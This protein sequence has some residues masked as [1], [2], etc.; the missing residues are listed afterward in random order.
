MKR[1]L[2]KLPDDFS[3]HISTKNTFRS[4][5]DRKK[6]PSS[7]STCHGQ[8][9]IS[10]SVTIVL[11]NFFRRENLQECTFRVSNGE[12]ILGNEVGTAGAV[13]KLLRFSV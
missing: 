3:T 13:E 2:Y 7:I 4:V 1:R 6:K 8:Y 11:F 9:S 10:P 12:R 5:F